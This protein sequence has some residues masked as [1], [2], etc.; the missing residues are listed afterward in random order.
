[1]VDFVVNIKVRYL[2]YRYWLLKVH[3]FVSPHEIIHGYRYDQ[4][5]IIRS[6]LD[7]VSKVFKNFRQYQ[8]YYYQRQDIYLI[9]TL[10]YLVLYYRFNFI[11]KYTTTLYN[12][13]SGG[14]FNLT[15]IKY[16]L[17]YFIISFYCSFA[18][19]LMLYKERYV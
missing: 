8:H 15:D 9:M 10:S 7:F 1:M 16:L 13:N 14:C 6:N 19:L 4:Y 18:T 12:I 3:H 11:K 2:Y 17:I 5:Y